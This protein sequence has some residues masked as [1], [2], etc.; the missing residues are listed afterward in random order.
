[1]KDDNK[2]VV[3]LNALGACHMEAGNLDRALDNFN[4][5]KIALSQLP[6]PAPKLE[7][8]VETNI[9]TVSHKRATD[10]SSLIE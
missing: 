1:M 9:L 2:R 10:K 5:A 6:K 4:K 8:I 3:R 7:I